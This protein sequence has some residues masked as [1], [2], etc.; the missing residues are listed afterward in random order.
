MGN[1]PTLPEVAIEVMRLTQDT[2]STITDLVRIVEKDVALA[3]SILRAANSAYYGVPRKIDSMKMA[4]V[5]L[6]MNEIVNLVM[7]VSVFKSFSGAE[8]GD[9]FDMGKF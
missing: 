3:S 5:I 6:G 9:D 2:K 1:L 8:G 4:V 7:G